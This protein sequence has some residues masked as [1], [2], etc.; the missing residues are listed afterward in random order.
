MSYKLDIAPVE[1][2]DI[3]DLLHNMR[4]DDAQELR[5]VYSPES[6]SDV[7]RRTVESSLVKYA[8]RIPES[9]RLM[10]ICGVIHENIMS[11][12]GCIWE[13]GTTAMAENPRLV[14]YNSPL[15]V[16]SMMEATPN[17]TVYYNFMP[18]HFRH[19]RKWAE[20]LLNARFADGLLATSSGSSIVRFTIERGD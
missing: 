1:E 3:E 8:C 5:I 7:V 2:R 6:V 11:D 15:M 19:Y 18:A 9:G 20:K 4:P 13:I 12:R 14:V 10:C 16:K 17:I